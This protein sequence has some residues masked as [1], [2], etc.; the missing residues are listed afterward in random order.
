MKRSQPSPPW[1]FS[2]SVK[3]W[4][5][6]CQNQILLK[7]PHGQ[8]GLPKTSSSILVL[9]VETIPVVLIPVVH[10]PVCP[11]CAGRGAWRGRL[12]RLFPRRKFHSLHARKASKGQPFF[13]CVVDGC[14]QLIPTGDTD[15]GQNLGTRMSHNNNIVYAPNMWLRIPY[16]YIYTYI[17]II[18]HP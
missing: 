13:F 3:G 5:L 1:V 10:I 11:M 14:G 16:V 9:L 15:M 4:W 2:L 8:L 17:Y 7:M 12:W 18:Q 6:L